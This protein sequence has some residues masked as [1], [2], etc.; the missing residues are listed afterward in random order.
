MWARGIGKGNGEEWWPRVR[1]LSVK[2]RVSRWWPRVR[3]LGMK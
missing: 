2:Y 3:V 1:V